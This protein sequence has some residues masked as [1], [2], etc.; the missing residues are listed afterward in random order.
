LENIK[1][2][3]GKFYQTRDGRK[4]FVAALVENPFGETESIYVARGYIND[5]NV[6]RG[7]TASGIWYVGEDNKNDL[8]AEWTEPKRIKGWLNISS[9]ATASPGYHSFQCTHIFKT[10]ELADQFANNVGPRIACIEIDVLEG[11]G[12]DGSAA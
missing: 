10:R 7:W 3:A 1:L 6:E 9:Q 4:A 12:L 5:K 11:Q 8:I 2:E